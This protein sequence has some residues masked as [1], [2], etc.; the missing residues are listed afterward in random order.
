[1]DQLGRRVRLAL[2]AQIPPFPDRK[3]R[4]ARWDPLDLK[5]PRA[6]MGLMALTARFPVLPDRRDLKGRLVRMERPLLFPG[7]RVPSGRRGPRDR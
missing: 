6:S 1:M 3:A 5:D 4:R 2:R 7:H